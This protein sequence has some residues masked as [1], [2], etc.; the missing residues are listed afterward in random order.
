MTS[1]H[2]ML[3]EAK[4]LLQEAIN[5]GP[6]KEHVFWET[7][8]F[9]QGDSPAA[10]RPS[11]YGGGGRVERLSLSQRAFSTSLSGFC[12]P[13]FLF[14]RDCGGG[15][16]RLK[17]FPEGILADEGT[18][19][20][21]V[22]ATPGRFGNKAYP[23]TDNLFGA[24]LFSRIYSLTGGVGRVVKG[25]DAIQF[26]RTSGVHELSKHLAKVS[27]QGVAVPGAEGGQVC[28]LVCNFSGSDGL[29][30]YGDLWIPLAVNLFLCLFVI[31]HF[32]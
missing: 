27:E 24:D 18:A 26:D 16:A 10:A 7:L 3:S 21:L 2:V 20:D 12:F 5:K 4:H 19:G 31:G 9:I 29:A 8:H 14:A 23:G 25:S 17:F 15:Y 11:P 13:A 6:P 1:S 22:F 28:Q 30:D 32:I